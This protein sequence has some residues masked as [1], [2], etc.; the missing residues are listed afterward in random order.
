MEKLFGIPIG[1]LMVNLIIIFIIG[2][3][4]LGYVALRNR[5]ILKLAVRNIPRR[6]AQ[7][8]L[9][10]MG[11]MLATL[12]F[13]ASFSTG[14]TL[15]HSLRVEAVKTLGE[16]DVLVR[17]KEQGVA[18]RR[19]Y[20]DQSYLKQVQ[21]RLAG[22][23]EVEAIGPFALER[24]PVLA[25]STRLS[26]PEVNVVGM[27]LEGSHVFARLEDPR[28]SPL[29][30]DSL[31]PGQAY[32]SSE[33]ATKLQAGP[34]DTILAV[35]GPQPTAIQVAGVFQEGASLAGDLAVVMPLEQIQ[36]AAG[37]VG[38]V[39]A[40]GISN[41]GDAIA[42]ARLTTPV[43][44]ALTPL[45]DGTPLEAA[46]VKEEALEMADQ[47]GS[48]IANVFLLFAQFSI[49]AGILL[50]FLI[51]TMLAAE[52]KRELGIMRAVGAQ[53]GHV[54]RLFAF[55]G[56][57]YSLLAAAV[58]SLLGVV[59]G[60]GMVRIMAQGLQEFDFSLTYTFNWRSLVIAYTMG[61]VVT[62]AVVLIASWRV[63]S[64]NIIRAI[65]DIPEPPADRRGLRALVVS[66]ALLLLGIFL[67][68]SGI[69]GEQLAPYLLGGSL[70]IIGL[71][72]IAQRQGLPDRAA[73]TFAGLAN[74]TWWLL[75]EDAHLTLF[76][77]LERLQAGIEMFFLTGIMVVIG[78]V[79]TVIY[80]TDLLLAA[81][82]FT[83][84]R[85]RGLPP[86]LKTAVAYPA[87]HRFRTGMTLAMVAL[88]IFTL[89]VMAF[90]TH[91]IAGVVGDTDR[92][93]GGFHILASTSYANPIKDIHAALA[94]AQ[95]IS[96]DDFSIIGSFLDAPIKARQADTDQEAEDFYLR[97]VDQGYVQGV[98][99]GFRMM[100]QGYQS[101]QEVWHALQQEPNTVVVASFIVPSRNNFNVGGAPGSLR[102]EGF[103]LEDET[104][105]EVYLEVTD[106]RSGRQE[107]LRIIGVLED[108]AVYSAPAVTSKGTLDRLLGQSLP[109]LG[110]MFRLKEGADAQTV[111]RALK[112]AFLENGFQAEVLADE[113]RKNSSVNL[114][115]TN[116]LQ[117][118]MSLGLVVGIAA[119]GVIAARSVVERRQEIGM[120][121][122]L[123]F[124][125]GM[126][127][128]SFLIESSFVA[129]LGIG[130]GVGLGFAI[131][132]QILG[133][134]AESFQGLT[135]RVPW[136]NILIV[137]VVA[138]LA[139]FLTTFLPAR[140]A[141]QV[142]PAE[143]L[144]Y[145]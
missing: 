61:M 54:V 123:G 56:A 97:G 115:F 73:F 125:K 110:Y 98:T 33:L 80:N 145:E 64:L 89:T 135:Y 141:A 83:F 19:D 1:Q 109:P 102:L 8:L 59:V 99:Y 9:I 68:F 65:R 69:Q 11:L 92:L 29:S 23:A 114:M 6:P 84:G 7:T 124:Q 127:Q 136:V 113:I 72:L 129:L 118:F 24:V 140:Q 58:G 10:V 137:V 119:L 48:S 122:A 107:R 38:K 13:S 91:A 28:G 134:M 144:R 22:M 104:L 71:S 131:S 5:V 32:I 78:A 50:I 85:L 93:S 15:T 27:S 37:T 51:F 46:P 143:A 18:G 82:V 34:G 49:A 20:F 42:G 106:P 79:W 103:Y 96:P 21:E 111:T 90:I 55:E 12:L 132:P 87:F 25:P 40:I 130:I 43:V 57:V 120:L 52:R 53:R 142:Y 35:L 70:I 121:R 126:V 66:I 67:M 75:P 112:A 60:W 76:P 86:V 63:S 4:V 77:M 101:P 116:L 108:L 74:L 17:T 31:G 2:A 16:V 26:E 3:A 47:N 88:V 81:I 128:T 95:G 14:D 30:L 41:Q 39:N 45:L 138:Y 44:D 133:G 139:S 100:A 105:P 94:S 62:F 117:G 36:I